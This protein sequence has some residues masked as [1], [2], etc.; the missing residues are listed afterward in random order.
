VT[1]A[2]DRLVQERGPPAGEL[3]LVPHEVLVEALG[4]VGAPDPADLADRTYAVGQV[5]DGRPVVVMS[6]AQHALLTHLGLLDVVLEHERTHHGPG[7]PA[8]DAVAHLV[9][10]DHRIE[11]IDA[12]L[13][14]R[15]EADLRRRLAEGS[16]ETTGIGV[17][18]LLGR[19]FTAM[20]LGG[21]DELRAALVAAT[22]ELLDAGLAGGQ[23]VAAL[24]RLGPPRCEAPSS[25]VAGFTTH[26]LKAV[27]ALTLLPLVDATWIGRAALIWVGAVLLLGVVAA[28]GNRLDGRMRRASAAVD[29]AIAAIVHGDVVLARHRL[30]LELS[31]LARL[32]VWWSPT[33]VCSRSAC[34]SP[35]GFLA[36]LLRW[37][38]SCAHGRRR[39]ARRRG[40]CPPTAP[41][42][43][44]G[45]RMP[46]WACVTSTP[47]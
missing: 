6:T 37:V 47:T 45:S 16:A 46:A 36:L 11:L 18:H 35:D 40:C 31:S 42:G 3:M 41:A 2:G 14:G 28:V 7:A 23:R 34:R 12:Q 39:P 20:R 30:R 4:R 1:A 32:P 27:P 8:H 44:S 21:L 33:T 5:V 13:A 15:V 43:T 26:R 9:D 22:A 29:Q 17:N 25:R 10:T 24:L 19:R 38:A